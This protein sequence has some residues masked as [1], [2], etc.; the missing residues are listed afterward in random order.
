VLDVDLLSAEAQAF[1]AEVRRFLADYDDPDLSGQYFRGRHGPAR[2]LY[3]AL[4]ERGW[5]SLS[6]PRESGGSA[7]PLS[8]E[9][10][11]WDELA[12]A[13]YAR[14]DL[15][16]GMVAATIIRH[17]TADQKRRLLPGIRTGQLVFALGYS[18]PDAG[19]DLTNLRTRAV[20]D[21]DH[22]VVNGQ[23][24]W[25]SDAHHADRL[26]LL[27]RTGAPDSRSRGLSLFAL[28]LHSNGVTLSPIE[29]IDGHRL[30]EVFLDDVV[31]PATDRIGPEH[32]A[33]SMMR[34]ALAVERHLQMLPGRL[35]RDLEDL[36]TALE[37]AGRLG[38]SDVQAVL[39]DHTARLA[40]VIVSSAATVSELEAGRDGVVHAARTKL[41]GTSLAQA[42]PRSAIDL[43]GAPLVAAGQPFALL[44]PQSMMETIGGGTSE[45]M[46]GIV[47]RQ[48]LRLGTR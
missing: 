18:E 10:V 3:R 40:E 33:W 19:S 45:I 28:D 25:T 27:A 46:R 32:Q 1:R 37:I 48:A 41:L 44:W 13:R 4:G 23:K 12:Y 6:W 38:D 43:I 21:G 47:A 8:H 22:Y 7:R 39:A 36:V 35:R 31:V 15:G 26:W 17:G 24:C 5:L 34:E 16:P 2:R 11:L 29:T 14:P 9:L 42:I 30:N 20:A